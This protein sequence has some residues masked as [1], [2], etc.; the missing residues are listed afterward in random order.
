[1][2]LGFHLVLSGPDSTTLITA[3][4]DGKIRTWV[5]PPEPDDAVNAICHAVGR[6]LTDAEWSRL[7]RVQPTPKT[8]P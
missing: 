8:G 6:N 3:S 1:M 5:R 4:F 2:N 7:T